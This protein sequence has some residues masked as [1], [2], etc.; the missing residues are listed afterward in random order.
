MAV[1]TKIVTP[2]FRL[3]FP[4]VWEPKASFK[5]T[6]P[7]YSIRMLFAKTEDIRELKKLAF[8][9]IVGQWGND[10]AK[11]PGNLRTLNLGTFLSTTG[12]D[13]W[14]FRDGD[15]QSY[16]GY[17]GCVVVGATAK[18]RPGVVDNKL[19]PIIDKDDLYAGCYCRASITAFAFEKRNEQGVIISQGVSFGLQNLMKTRDGEPFSGRSRAEDDFAD[20]S[21][22]DADGA[23][24]WDRPENYQAPEDDMFK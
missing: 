7:K 18:D 2:E 23:P 8:D 5:G 10:K 4:A 6:D 14:P 16:D 17:A 1:R 11:W 22:G 15:S 19:K 21:A 12:K 3:S 13:G 20:Y 9:T 24:E